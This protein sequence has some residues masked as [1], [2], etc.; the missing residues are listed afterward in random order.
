M[1]SAAMRFAVV[2]LVALPLACATAGTPANA[3]SDLITSEQLQARHFL[4][5]YE[6]VQALH[7]NWLFVRGVNSASTPEQVVVYED[8]T[9]VGGVDELRSIPIL[10]VKSIQHFDGNEATARWGIGH[11]AGAIQVST[12]SR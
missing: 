11:G 5:A 1:G 6:A 4:N 12:F 8:L 7:A 3:R 9:R 10:T 2:L